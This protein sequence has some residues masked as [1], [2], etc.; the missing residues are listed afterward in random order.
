MTRV[1]LYD[2]MLERK[3]H[4]ELRV[5]CRPRDVLRALIKTAA[6]V[7]RGVA[8]RIFRASGF[9]HLRLC[10]QLHS[11]FIALPSP[12]SFYIR[13]QAEER[14]EWLAEVLIAP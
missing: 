14:T 13:R 1:G 5:P 8:L 6:K 3:P 7:A 10:G 4:F 12:S 9:S 11:E 2:S